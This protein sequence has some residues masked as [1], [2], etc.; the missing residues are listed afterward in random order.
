MNQIITTD[1]RTYKAY[2]TAKLW[3]P[4]GEV[5]WHKNRAGIVRATV[6]LTRG[7][8]MDTDIIIAGYFAQS[9]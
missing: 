1:L 6:D 3:V 7:R 4:L 5:K 2:V 8:K 9:F